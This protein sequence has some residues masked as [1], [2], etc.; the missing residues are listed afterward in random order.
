MQQFVGGTIFYSDRNALDQQA[1]GVVGS[2]SVNATTGT[3]SAGRASTGDY[4]KHQ[5]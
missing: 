1:A 2:V 4:G 3:T 5:D